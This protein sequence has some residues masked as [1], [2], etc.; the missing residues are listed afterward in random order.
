MSFNKKKFKVIKNA[1]S[2]E[3]AKLAYNYLIIKRNAEAQMFTENFLPP[4][5][6]LSGT[7][8]D[9]Q[10]PNTYSIYGDPFMETL[11]L[12]LKPLMKK[13]TGLDLYESYSYARTYKR[14]DILKRHK[15]RPSCEISTT[16]NLGG[17]P[18]PIFIE[19][20]N[21]IILKPGDMLIYK[22]CELEHW[23]DSF[24]GEVC[25]Q[26]FLH[27]RKDKKYIYDGRPMV[28]FPA[29]YRKNE[30]NK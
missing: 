8:E 12:Y 11:L 7:W 6:A 10:V 22:G 24:D 21:K 3:I 27:Y 20:S 30:D 26:V 28:G 2:K 1:I 13:Q 15:D 19:P 29:A 4:F 16:L 5:E 18:W 25:V 14:G 23:R 17:D 9:E